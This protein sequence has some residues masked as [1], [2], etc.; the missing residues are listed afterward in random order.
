MR[1]RSL[2]VALIVLTTLLFQGQVNPSRTTA[3]AAT[4]I[5]TIPTP[6]ADGVDLTH[7]PL[8]DNRHSTGPKVGYIWPCRIEA[9]AGGAFKVGTWIKSDG[10][11]DFTKKAVVDGAVNWPNHDLTI[12]LQGDKRII[13]T[14]DLP[15][16][17]TGIF[18]I[19][20]SDDAYAYDRNPN[21]IAAQNF[22]MELPAN[23][24]LLAQPSCAPGAVGILLSGV[25]L[26]N[27]LDA[28]GRDAV[29]HETQD[30]CQGHPQSSGTYHYHSLTNCLSDTAGSDG[31]SA[32]MGYS[33]DGFGIYGRHGQG[34]QILT[35]ADLDE[36]HGHTHTLMWDGKE[37]SM[38]H[39]HTTWDFPYTVGCM[40]GAY[41]ISAVMILSGGPAGGAGNGQPNGQP[42]GGQPNNPPPPNGQPGNGQPRNPPPPPR[43]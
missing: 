27:A 7:L 33:V 38:Y 20:P 18:P 37:V 4:D 42:N 16:H 15:N 40:R 14:N 22:Q 13:A 36:C 34:G 32:L 23:P 6:D 35:S 3:A 39:Y 2:A 8:G 30:G 12:T 41:Q 19:A 24:T 43:R 28:P 5:A 29:A 1:Y 21:K 11:Y 9:D 10:T 26:F 31:H 17:P 25:S